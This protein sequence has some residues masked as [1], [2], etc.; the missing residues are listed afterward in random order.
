MAFTYYQTD[1]EINVVD[2]TKPHDEFAEIAFVMAMPLGDPDP[3]RLARLQ[4][5][6]GRPKMSS[7]LKVRGNLVDD[8]ADIDYYLTRRAFG[9]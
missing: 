3:A 2:W 1:E 4:T 6:L 5:N 8:L 7:L 9:V